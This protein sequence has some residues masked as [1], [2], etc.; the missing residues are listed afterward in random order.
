[1]TDISKLPWNDVRPALEAEAGVYLY[2]IRGYAGDTGV[3]GDAVG[4]YIPGVQQTQT[5]DGPLVQFLTTI[6]P[7]HIPMLI[8]PNRA[9]EICGESRVGT[10]KDMYQTFL[11]TEHSG[12]AAAYGDGSRDGTANANAE[13]V[14]RQ[15]MLV[16]AFVEAG[17]LE[18]ERWGAGA[19][20]ML[21]QRR[22]AQAE[23]LNK[24]LN[25]TYFSGV[26][27]LLNYGLLND[28]SLSPAHAPTTGTNGISWAQKAMNRTD[29]ALDIYADFTAAYGRI[30][31]NAQGVLD[32]NMDTTTKIIW[33]ISPKNRVYLKTTNIY[34]VSVEGMIKDAF[35]NSEI[36]TAPEM[37]TESGSL[38]Y[39][40]V[41]E[42]DGIRTI[43]LYFSERFR[44]HRVEL[45]SSMMR[46]KATTGSY[47]AFV[48]RP[49]LID[50]TL[51]V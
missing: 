33:M 25:T 48:A 18:I 14:Q 20:D 21:G 3:V 26:D 34:G 38:L 27:G 5:N 12:Y 11:L 22:L 32:K 17:D 39:A 23:T 45:E 4:G 10:W 41:P 46:Q 16:Q 36:E 50:M 1:M 42:L 8:A 6:Q 37:D 49:L 2:G 30:Q 24:W 40:F 9:A 7:Q 13:N 19:F 31:D 29:G 35:P 51:G 43:Q 15:N 44:N 47:G 28:P